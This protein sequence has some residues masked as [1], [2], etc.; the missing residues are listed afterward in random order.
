MISSKKGFS[1]IELLVAI[2]IIA[3]LSSVVIVSLSNAKE[4]ARISSARIFSANI[5]HT[6]GAYAGGVW[7]ME[8]G[9]GNVIQDSSGW[10]NT[11]TNNGATWSNDVPF[12]DFEEKWSLY[13][14]GSNYLRAPFNA[15]TMNIKQEGFTYSAWI[16]PTALTNTYNM[17]MGQHLPYF[18]VRTTGILHMSMTAGGSQRSVYGVTKIDLNK[19]YHVAATYDPQGYM[20]VYLDGKLDGTAGPFVGPTNGS[21]DFYIGQ[22]NSGGTYRFTGYIARVR[23]YNNALSLSQIQKMYADGISKYKLAGK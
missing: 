12:T 16:K 5:Y 9:S 17:F 15:K 19:W 8:E 18:N 10:N 4:K 7:L 13:F 23:Y 3:V 2:S 11:A 22:W 20:K 1:I 14:N 6:S 21:Y